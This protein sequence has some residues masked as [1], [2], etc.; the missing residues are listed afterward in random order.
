[1]N[2]RNDPIFESYGGGAIAP[3]SVTAVSVKA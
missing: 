1:M 3:G 2:Y